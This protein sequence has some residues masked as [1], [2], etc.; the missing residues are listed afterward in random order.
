M[1]RG[2][3]SSYKLQSRKHDWRSSHE[4]RWITKDTI[5]TVGTTKPFN[6]SGTGSFLEIP[7]L[8]YLTKRRQGWRRNTISRNFAIAN[9]CYII[10][11][12]EEQ[13]LRLHSV[14]RKKRKKGR[15]TLKL[16]PLE[17]NRF[18]FFLETIPFELWKNTWRTIGI[19]IERD[20]T[21]GNTSE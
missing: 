15:S 17:I 4:P 5:L 8:D 6:Y 11:W 10:S 19:F 13:L 14:E 12:T 7:S 3:A 2:Y 20:I 21:L 18:F 9:N 16:F 1:T